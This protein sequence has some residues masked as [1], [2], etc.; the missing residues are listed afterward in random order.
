MHSF[1]AAWYTHNVGFAWY[2]PNSIT[3][4][5]LRSRGPTWTGLVEIAPTCLQLAL[6]QIPLRCGG[7]RP[8][9]RPVRHRSA[10][11]LCARPGRRPVCACRVRYRLVGSWLKASCEPNCDH[12]WAVSTCRD[13]SN[14]SAT[15]RKLGLRPR[16]V[17]EFG[18]IGLTYQINGGFA[19]SL[20]LGCTRFVCVWHH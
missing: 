19:S 5:S 15:G 8:G 7:G 3:L 4:S 17:M 10:T 13:S 6:G 9:F 2:S 11:S 14:L 12:V 16:Y 20:W 1:L 18:L